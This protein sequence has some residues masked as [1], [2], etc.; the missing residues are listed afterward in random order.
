[1]AARR[2]PDLLRVPPVRMLA[3][4]HA[5]A[6]IAACALLACSASESAPASPADAP[7]DEGADAFLDG[8]CGR[9]GASCPTAGA[10]VTHCSCANGNGVVLVCCDSAGTSHSLGCVDTTFHPTCAHPF[11][12]PP[13]TGP[14]LDAELHADDARDAVSDV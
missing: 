6:A 2:S 3:V 5:S 1:M 7:S 12:E 9:E 10:L 4:R 13:E 8:T 14:G 11:G